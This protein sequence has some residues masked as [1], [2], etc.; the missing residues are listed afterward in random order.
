MGQDGTGEGQHRWNVEE[1]LSRQ[2]S[3]PAPRATDDTRPSA[4]LHPASREMWQQIGDGIVWCVR[5]YCC[6]PDVVEVLVKPVQANPEI[7][8]LP[9]EL[10]DQLLGGVDSDV[11][12]ER[13]AWQVQENEAE[14][15]QLLELEVPDQRGVELHLGCAEASNEPLFREPLLLEGTPDGLVVLERTPLLVGDDD[16][17]DDEG[18]L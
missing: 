2:S 1:E 5:A 15:D 4:T 18:A 3:P 6:L 16:D 14:H 13:P 9:D 12:K 17:D 7:L 10:L 11:D 8:S